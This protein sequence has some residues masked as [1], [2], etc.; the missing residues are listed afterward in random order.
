MRQHR[1]HMTPAECILVW[2]AVLVQMSPL[3]AE[4]MGFWQPD[5][6]DVRVVV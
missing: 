6:D 2:E 3:V 1:V 4:L 5:P